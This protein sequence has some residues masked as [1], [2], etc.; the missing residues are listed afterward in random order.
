MIKTKKNY[1]FLFLILFSV[2]CAISIGQAWDEGHLLLQGKIVAKYLLSLGNINEDIFIREY[3]SP[4]YYSLKY[5]FI[6]IF[7]INYQIEANHLT[8]LFFSLCTIIGI[9][10]LSKELFNDKVGIIVFLILF[11]YP[12]FNGHMGFNSKDTIL[13]LCHVWIFY[14]SIK[15]L[16]N[17]HNKKK[18]NNY[19]NYIAILAAVGSGINLYFLGSLLPLFIFLILDFY[20]FKKIKSKKFDT[21]RLMVNLLYGFFV[22]YL[23]LVTFWIDTHQNIVILPFKLFLEWFSHDFTWVGYPYILVNGNYYLYEDIPKSYLFINLIL[24][25]PEYFLLLYALFPVIIL[26]SIAFYKKKFPFFKYKLALI[27]SMIIFPFC[28]LYFTPFSIY[29]G[30]RHVLWILPYICI[31]P[32]LV[33]YYLFENTKNLKERI[34]LSFTSLLIIYF[35]FN[36]FL[37]TPYQY[38]YLNAF[39]GEIKYRY[40]KFEN[41]YWGASLKELME[42]IDFDKNSKVKFATCGINQKDAK[43]YLKKNG[44][45]KVRFGNELNSTYMMMTNRVTLK[46]GNSYETDN[47]TNCYDKF[48]GQDVFKVTRNGIVLSVIR[49]IN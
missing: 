6:Q 8:N 25:S 35:L 45:T 34:T 12:A 39:N 28:L 32:A 16:K 48:K 11:F 40:K 23:L 29:D 26:G 31:I 20:I 37:T 19:I 21:K 27:L 33:I 42:K 5:L 44:F 22:F 30:L 18:T 46:K 3:Y 15:Y 7:P 41:D 13:A 17:Q 4:I 43:I 9:K 2:Y 49:K 14:L 38:T 47:L 24:R 1:L 36:F 10:K